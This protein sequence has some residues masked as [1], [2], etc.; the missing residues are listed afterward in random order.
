MRKVRG[1]KEGGGNN[2][3]IEYSHWSR[4]SCMRMGGLCELVPNFSN[5]GGV[6]TTTKTARMKSSDR[7]VFLQ[8]NHVVTRSKNEI[9]HL[10][11]KRVSGCG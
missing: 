5:P 1:R 6:K 8:N 11:C 10:C 2:T 3:K 9:M 4:L 7:N